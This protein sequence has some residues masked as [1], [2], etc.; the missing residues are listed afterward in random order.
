MG[1]EGHAQHACGAAPPARSNIQS[2]IKPKWRVQ[3]P[4]VLA[5]QSSQFDQVGNF[6]AHQADGPPEQLRTVKA[7]NQGAVN[8]P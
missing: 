6:R 8:N 4:N 7:S 2:L 3:Y 5:L 1:F